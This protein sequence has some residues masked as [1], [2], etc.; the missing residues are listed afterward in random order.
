MAAAA[1]APRPE[2]ESPAGARLSTAALR[3]ALAVGRG[4]DALAHAAAA[5]RDQVRDDFRVT[6]DVLTTTGLYAR[7]NDLVT[8]QLVCAGAAEMGLDLGR[9][10]WL[11]FGSQGRSE[12]TPATDQDNGWVLCGSAAASERARWLELG[13]RVNAALA[14]CGYTLCKGQVMAGQ[15]GCCLTVGEWCGRFDA[16]IEHGAPEDLLAASIYFDLR[17]LVGRVDL[18]AAMRQRLTTRA[19]AV[20]RFLKQLADN[21]LRHAV[22][23]DWLGRVRPLRRNGCAVFDLKLSGTAIFVETARLY[24]LAHG[25]AGTGTVERL[26][27]VARALRV[28]AQESEAWRVGFVGLQ[29]LR[30]RAHAGGDW[31]ADNPNLIGLD[32]L[33]PADRQILKQ[34]L[35]AAR[36]LQQRAELDYWR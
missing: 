36:L 12:Q 26:D 28:P 18:A 35:R 14:V 24:A 5:I 34:G 6:G 3:A 22:P 21:A 30:L 13:Q 16:W 8:E 19:A 32:A 20:P 4:T 33:V 9:A 7:I 17:G 31:P 23:M 1:S 29:C 2:P 11:A 25:I 10:C 15:P 27:A